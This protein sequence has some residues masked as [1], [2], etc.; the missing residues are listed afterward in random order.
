MS[1]E[2]ICQHK[3]H[4]MNFAKTYHSLVYTLYKNKLT[5]VN[6]TME[7]LSSVEVLLAVIFRFWK[8]FSPK[9]S[10]LTGVLQRAL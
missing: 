6:S 4:L 9:F 2:H 5:C 1:D 3:F 10:K 7:K 8:S